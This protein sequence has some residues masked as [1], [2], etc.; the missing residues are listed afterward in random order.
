MDG[1]DWIGLDWIGWNQSASIKE[2]NEGIEW[3]CW[4][5]IGMDLNWIGCVRLLVS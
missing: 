2:L 3:K 5:E 1:L 4:M